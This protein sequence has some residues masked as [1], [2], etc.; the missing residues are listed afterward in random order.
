[1]SFDDDEFLDA[2]D[3]QEVVEFDQEQGE[4]SD[5]ELNLSDVEQ[6]QKAEPVELI[7]HSIQGFFEHKGIML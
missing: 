2:N 7:D 3:I 1:M 5:D 4:P 6:D